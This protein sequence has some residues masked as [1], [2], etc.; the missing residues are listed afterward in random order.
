MRAAAV[1]SCCSATS[2]HL[3]MGFMTTGPHLVG[4]CMRNWISLN[5]KSIILVA[6]K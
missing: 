6:H 3:T 4:A 2:N 5:I 1:Q